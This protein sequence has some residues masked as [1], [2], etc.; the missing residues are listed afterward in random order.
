MV[1]GSR[2]AMAGVSEPP[3]HLP[4]WL[5]IALGP[6]AAPASTERALR[7]RHHWLLDAGGS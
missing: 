5:N 6:A 1:P 2:I 7:L 4:L 3:I